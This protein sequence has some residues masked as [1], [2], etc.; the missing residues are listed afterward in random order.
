VVALNSQGIAAVGE[1][2]SHHNAPILQQDGARNVSFDGTECSDKE[3]GSAGTNT[4]LVMNTVDAAYTSELEDKL[5]TLSIE[6]HDLDRKNKLI[7]QELVKYQQSHEATQKRIKDLSAKLIKLSDFEFKEQETARKLQEAVQQ[8]TETQS[9]LA[10]ADRQHM[11]YGNTLNTIY[12]LAVSLR[13]TKSGR[14]TCDADRQSF[15]ETVIDLISQ[16]QL[17]ATISSS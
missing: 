16:I 11:E 17:T 2:Q 7:N 4:T 13:D 15:L 14:S 3:S 9:R 5:A 8:L 12:G 6:K 10:D 1:P